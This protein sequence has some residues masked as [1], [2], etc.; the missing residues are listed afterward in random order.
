MAR[1]LKGHAFGL[2]LNI[3]LKP[4]QTEQSGKSTKTAYFSIDEIPDALS[5][6]QAI[7]EMLKADSHYNGLQMISLLRHPEIEKELTSEESLTTLSGAL[8]AQYCTQEE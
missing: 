7:N 6:D 1:D 2:K 5:V 8:P 4:N 3:L